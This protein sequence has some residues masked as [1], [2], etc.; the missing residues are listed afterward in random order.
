MVLAFSN[1][2]FSA[3]AA[4]KQD[5]LHQNELAYINSL[6]EQR[7]QYSYLQG[8]FVAKK[9]LGV[10]LNTT[11]LSGIDIGYGIFHQPV[12][13]TQGTPNTQISITHSAAYAAAIVFPEN[14]SIGIDIEQVDPLRNWNEFMSFTAHES[15]IAAQ[16]NQ[17]TNKLLTLFW[18]AKE[19]LSKA[20]KLGFTIDAK[21]YEMASCR[22]VNGW[23]EST[24][25]YFTPF[26]AYSWY[27]GDYCWSIVVPTHSI[28][29]FHSIT[30]LI[31]ATHQSEKSSHQPL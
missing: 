24:F 18:T 19:A 29:E 2:L 26:K 22:Y 7:R 5:Y 1:N 10:Y 25:V 17:D 13:Y 27:A 20:I 14:V 16:I 4:S 11:N 15:A 12:I 31:K 3:L 21:L 30:G 6:P 8:R 23:L 9:A 28:I